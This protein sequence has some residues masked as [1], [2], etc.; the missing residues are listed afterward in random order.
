ANPHMPI[1]GTRLDMD[2]NIPGNEALR[3]GNG[4]RGN[5]IGFGQKITGATTGSRPL[6]QIFNGIP[7]FGNN[8]LGGR[9]QNVLDGG[10]AYFA[11]ERLN[12]TSISANTPPKGLAYQ[13]T[14]LDPFQVNAIL[15]AEKEKLKERVVTAPV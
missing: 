9:L 7:F 3:R 8:Y 2:P 6:G 13:A 12:S 14:I 4:G 10:D 11:G 1:W 5:D 15:R